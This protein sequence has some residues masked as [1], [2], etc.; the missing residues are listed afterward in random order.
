MKRMTIV[1]VLALFG[2]GV[3]S[4]ESGCVGCHA[5][6]ARMKALFVPPAPVASEGEG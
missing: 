1:A 2:W 6:D 4:A 5:D 3:A